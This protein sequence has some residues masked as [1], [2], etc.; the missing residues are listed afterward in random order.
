MDTVCIYEGRS[1][2]DALTVKGILEARN[3]V[4]IFPN[5]HIS[6][7]VPHYSSVTGGFNIMVSSASFLEAGKLL[8][9]RGYK[10][11]FNELID[12]LTAI[13]KKR[14]LEECPHCGNVA[15][16]TV[17]VSKKGFVG[18]IRSFFGASV[19]EEKKEQKMC[20]LCKRKVRLQKK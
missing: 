7:V 3:I 10:I 18:S 16:D 11:K 15:V 2:Q 4:C 13:Q 14:N 5:E 17:M 20:L 8:N 19:P 12:E 1:H 9:S 6:G